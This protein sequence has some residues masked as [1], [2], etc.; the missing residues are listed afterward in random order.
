MY[1]VLSFVVALLFMF[2]PTLVAVATKRKLVDITTVFLLNV[3][4]VL[5]SIIIPVSFTVIDIIS[6]LLFVLSYLM[7]IEE[8]NVDKRS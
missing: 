5:V 6:V 8:T 3:A 4:L 1:L 2:Y 7:L